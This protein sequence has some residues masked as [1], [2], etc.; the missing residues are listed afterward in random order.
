M[1][2]LSTGRPSSKSLS[3]ISN[4]LAVS[5]NERKGEGGVG[6]EGE[7]GREGRREAGG[8][9]VHAAEETQVSLLGR[10]CLTE[11]IL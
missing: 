10:H 5:P 3:H 11:L 9:R 6:V 2:V 1:H 4:S 7:G 8:G